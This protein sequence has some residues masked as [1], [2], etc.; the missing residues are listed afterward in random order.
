[1]KFSKSKKQLGEIG[2]LLAADYY[3]NHGYVLLFKNWRWSNKG[4]LDLIAYNNHKEILVVCEV[5]T[6]KPGSLIKGMY[7]INTV[8]QNKIKMLTSVFV[9]KH[10][11]YER[12][13]VRFDVADIIYDPETNTTKE[14]TI[15]ENAF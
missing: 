10:N 1:M 3:L 15:I 8:K 4:E 2:E 7:S 6:R 11:V 13:N 5:K 14:F 12:C 9:Q